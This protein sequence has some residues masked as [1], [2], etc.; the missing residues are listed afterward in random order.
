MEQN[1]DA[2]QVQLTAADIQ[3]IENGFAQIQVQ[4]ARLSEAM[5]AIIDTGAKLGTSS[6]GGHGNSPLP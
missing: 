1:M 3:E 2:L 5:L 6:I 4:G